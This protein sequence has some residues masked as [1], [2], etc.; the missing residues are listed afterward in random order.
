MSEKSFV[1][2]YSDAQYQMNLGMQ[3][4]QNL[5]PIPD[6]PKVFINKSACMVNA[7]F[8]FDWNDTSYI[9]AW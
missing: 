4:I 5:S 3:Y 8:A 9:M 1:K 2:L 7:N 6:C